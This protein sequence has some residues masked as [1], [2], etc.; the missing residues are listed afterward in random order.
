[1]DDRDSSGT[2]ARA[3]GAPFGTHFCD[4]WAQLLVD[5]TA[6]FLCAVAAVD[7]EP[8]GPEFFSRKIGSSANLPQAACV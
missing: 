8:I 1:M 3:D 4:R 7:G 5:S 6:T 2:V